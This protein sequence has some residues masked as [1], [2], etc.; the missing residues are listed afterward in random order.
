MICPSLLELKLQG[1]RKI[2]VSIA[3]SQGPSTKPIKQQALS[4]HLWSKPRSGWKHAC[5][6]I[7]V[8]LKVRACPREPSNPRVFQVLSRA[9]RPVLW[10][11]LLWR[12]KETILSCFF[13]LRYCLQGV[14]VS[15]PTSPPAPPIMNQTKLHC[16]IAQDSCLLSRASLI[17]GPE[18][19]WI[20]PHPSR[21]GPCGMGLGTE[22]SWLRGWRREGQHRQS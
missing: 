3:V 21:Q 5:R 8:L 16:Q 18:S 6:G 14:P 12:K 15:L 4:K 7:Q 13:I 9:R 2:I 17:T 19:A 10:Q 20:T 22:W 1:H 11:L